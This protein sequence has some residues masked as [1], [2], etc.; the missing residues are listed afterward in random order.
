MWL[1][2][3][4]GVKIKLIIYILFKSQKAALLRKQKL[5]KIES[6]CCKIMF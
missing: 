6:W 4:A 5:L 1:L 3:S 2:Y